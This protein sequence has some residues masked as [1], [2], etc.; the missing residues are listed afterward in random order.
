MEIILALCEIEDSG[1]TNTTSLSVLQRITRQLTK[2]LREL[3]AQI[4]RLKKEPAWNFSKRT[5]LEALKTKLSI[6]MDSELGM[7]QD[8]LKNV[9]AMIDEWKRQA[10]RP[11]GKPRQSGRP[12]RRRVDPLEFLFD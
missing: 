4:G 11:A 1:H 6:Q 12:G 8:R 5:D 2:A 3:K 7:I 9:E 10:A